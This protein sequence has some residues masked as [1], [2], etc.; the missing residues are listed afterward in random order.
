MRD[1]T[2]ELKHG[3]LRGKTD[4]GAAAFLGIPFAAAPF[5]VNRMRPPQPVEAWNG[6]RDATEYGP[7]CP[8]GDYPPQYAQLFPEVTIAG[9]E[10]LN[11]NVWSP[12]PAASG[13][14][15]LVWIHGGSFTNG[16]GSAAEYRGSAFAR[17][18]IVC[19]TINYR[20]GAEGFL[21][22]G[23]GI[24][25]LGLLD[26]IAAL[27]WVQDN[28]AAFGGDPGRITVAGESAGA[29]SITNLLSMPGTAGL[30]RQAIAQ[31]GAAAH[32]LSA[33]EGRMVSGYLAGAL[34]VPP[35][36]DA[37]TA[38]PLD[39]VVQA[40]RALTDEVRTAP[41]PARWGRIA[42]DRLPFEPTIDGQ[43]LPRAPLES[44]LS[45]AGSDVRLM[46]GT[47]LNEARLF[48]VPTGVMDL[49]DDATVEAGAAAYGLAA[50]DVAVY[51]ANRP[52]ASN[53][54][55]L[56]AIITDWFYRVP[57]IRVA[58]A[59][60]ASPGTAEPGNTWMYRFDYQ[61]P[62]FD[63]QLG[64]C[65]GVEIPFVFDTLDVP[66]TRPRVGDNPPQPVA[67]TAHRVWVSFVADGSP[68][69]SSYDTTTRTTALINETAG[70]VND[71]AGG[72]RRLWEGRR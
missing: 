50:A 3:R 4:R 47:T 69:W 67:D 20:L 43:V 15:V 61:S 29:M 66:G 34:G 46:I 57:A 26:Q 32:T 63:G 14:P 28:I 16:S 13:L 59:R 52:G 62:A 5:G 37:I 30:F 39:Q 6:V 44:L 48:F 21:Y 7:T 42:L 22:L 38:L 18:G 45:G 10:C 24:A 19:V 40:A 71:P 31:S 1:A 8:K 56:A 9:E 53:G 35:S 11:L 68:G 72:E 64:A 65:H 12:D 23:D 55:V 33:A 36:R 27:H 17:D 25:N 58:E 41:D 54:D 2:V 51:R 49:V 60:A 70:I